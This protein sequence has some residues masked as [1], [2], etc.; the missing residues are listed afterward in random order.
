MASQDD[1]VK[2]NP[3]KQREELLRVLKARFEKNT[4][5][6]K[7]LEWAQVEARLEAG[8][9]KLWPL[10][11]SKELAVNRMLLVTT[12]ERANAFPVT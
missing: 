11:K 8:G 1:H 4:N 10:M 12:R 2:R 6:H 7:G 9:E 5:C 3:L